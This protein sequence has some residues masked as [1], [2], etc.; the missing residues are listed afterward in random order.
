MIMTNPTSTSK[1]KKTITALIIATSTIGLAACSGTS[2]AAP[3]SAKAEC[4]RLLDLAD[5]EL[6][7]AKGDT[8]GDAGRF[9]KITVII[10]DGSIARQFGAYDKCIRK[11]ERARYLL[12]PYKG[13]AAKK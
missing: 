4:T 1:I 13:T 3:G 12:R 8:I 9:T 7:A 11:A 10:S 2:T 5:K 6:A